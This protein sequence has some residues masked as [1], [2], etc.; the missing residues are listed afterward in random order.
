MMRLMVSAPMTRTFR[1]VPRGHQV[2]AGGEA[3]DE[4]GTGGDQVEAP[5]AARAESVLHQAGGGRETT[6]PA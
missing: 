1:C 3:V 6:C 2:G 4:A 5:G